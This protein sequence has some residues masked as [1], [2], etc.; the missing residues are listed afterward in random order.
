[1]LPVEDRWLLSRL[2]R[3]AAEVTDHLENYH[4]SD[5]ARTLYEFTWSEF[6]DWYVEMSKPR[7]L[8]AAA[9][10]LA[11]RVLVGVLDAILRLLHPIMPFVTE[12]IWQ[13]LAEAAFERG[14]PN[15]EPAAESVMIA[16]WPQF[17]PE[18]QDAAVEKRIGRMQ[19]LVRAVRNIRNQFQ[20]NERTP[21]EVSVRCDTAVAEDFQRLLPFIVALA[22]ISKLHCGATVAKPPQSAAA[23]H[24]EFEAY[25]H[26]QGLIDVEAET[27]RLAKQQADKEK[28]LQGVRGKLANA[29]FIKNAPEEVVA[30][31]RNLESDLIQQIQAIQENL[32]QLRQK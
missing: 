5:A 8:D 1:M 26:L 10:P 3:T 31:Q 12:S 20:V 16:P 25:V 15:P 17:P 6:C 27:K 4:F 24:P 11:Q 29:N 7:M 28:Q 2:A 13:A 14:L 23:I 9:R 32:Q 21:V 19:D 18:W 22:K 30:Q